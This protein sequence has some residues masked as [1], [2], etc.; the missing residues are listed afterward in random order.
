MIDCSPRTPACSIPSIKSSEKTA[1]FLWRANTARIS[2]SSALANEPHLTATDFKP[3]AHAATVNVSIA[4]AA[5]SMKH[6]RSEIVPF[7]CRF[8]CRESSALSVS[9]VEHLTLRTLPPRKRI[10]AHFLVEFFN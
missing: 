8:H 6:E 4:A 7:A 9:H 10:A 3:L 1:G 2:T 5:Y